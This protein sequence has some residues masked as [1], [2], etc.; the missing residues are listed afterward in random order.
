MP[1]IEPLKQSAKQDRPKVI[2]SRPPGA[3]PVKKVDAR[4]GRDRY[5][6]GR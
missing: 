5:R 4:S 3:G 1:W 6:R 2:K